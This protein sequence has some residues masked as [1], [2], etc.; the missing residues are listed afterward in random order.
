MMQYK[1]PQLIALPT[2]R[3]RSDVADWRI[4]RVCVL[5]FER[6]GDPKITLD[7]LSERFGL[8]ATHLGKRF[9]RET[10]QPFRHL[11]MALRLQYAAELL[12][13]SNLSVKEIAA[14]VGYGYPGDFDHAFQHLFGVCPKDYRQQYLASGMSFASPLDED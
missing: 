5:V 6:H 1:G 13:G 11:V 10:G 4:R 2:G 14:S 7:R 12:T 9:K 3:G 8:S